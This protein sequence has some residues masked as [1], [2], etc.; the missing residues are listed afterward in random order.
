[1]ICS[2]LSHSQT[3]LSTLAEEIGNVSV[4][5]GEPATFYCSILKHDTDFNITWRID[6]NEYICDG[7]STDS[8]DSNIFC[9]FNDSL[10]VLQIKD[11]D[12][13]GAGTY[14]LQCALQQIIPVNFTSADSFLAGFGDNV[15]RE[16]VLTVT[17]EL[18]HQVL[19]QTI[20]S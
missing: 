2:V 15:V 16:A 19:Y 17:G 3:V 12:P 18:L 5:V 7:Y 20:G 13:L 9:S 11:T 8:S 14:T 10:S 4:T 6:N 1:M